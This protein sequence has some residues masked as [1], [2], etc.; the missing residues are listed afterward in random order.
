MFLGVVTFACTNYLITK[1]ASKDGSVMISYAADSHTLY[2]EIYRWPAADYPAGAKLKIYEWD[3]GKFLGEIDQV[4][5]TYS[6]VGNMNEYQVAIGETTYGG[7]EELAGPSGIVDYGSLIYITLQRAK[8]AREAIKIFA[9]LTEK[10]GYASS[11]ESFSISDKNE[12]WIL[13]MIGKGKDKNGAVWVALKIPDGYVSGHANHAR[14]TTFPLENGKTSISSKNLKN[15]FNPEL[16]CV[17]SY[18]VISFA[19]EMKYFTGVDKDFSFSDTYAPVDFGGARF[20]EVRVWSMFRKV[21]KDMDKYFD[22]VSGHNP[23]NRM[24]LWILPDHKITEK[25]MFDFMR[26]HLEGTPLDM[27]VDLGAGP[28]GNPYRWRPLTW[29]VD[30]KTYCNERATATQQTG[31]SFIAQ[32]R[33][34][35]PDPIGGILWFSVDDAASTVYF[36]M[37]CG[38]TKVPYSF[39]VG[40]GDMMTYSKTSAHWTFNELSNFAYTRYN[41]IHPEID[42]LQDIIEGKYFEKV[43]DIDKNAVEKYNK[44]PKSAIDYITEFSVR[45]GDDLT[46]QWR[47]FYEFLFAKYMDGN[48]KKKLPVPENYKYVAPEVKQP[49]YSETW[50]RA[51]AGETGEKLLMPAGEGH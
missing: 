48:V 45:T 14:I 31:F 37:Y 18:D 39:S 3:T 12:V 2:G 29:E 26:D 34:W 19:K 32:S 38:A 8:S 24:P 50:K 22:Y 25:E 5:H 16:E 4:A 51:V 47:W 17:Y 13:E 35:L 20:C 23:K 21:N 40:N 30:G 41:L 43:K 42:S 44:D 28:W 1:G 9:E 46:N 27:T 15:I 33:S 7:R 10:Y 6:V 36:P 11:G 49:G